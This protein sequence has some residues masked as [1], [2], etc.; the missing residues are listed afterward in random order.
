MG[1][2]GAV[3][4]YRP[5]VPGVAGGGGAVPSHAVGVFRPIAAGVA[6]GGGRVPSTGE[7]TQGFGGCGGPGP[8]ALIGLR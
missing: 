1:W 6:G 3:V 7:V 5:I 8:G 2:R 4:P